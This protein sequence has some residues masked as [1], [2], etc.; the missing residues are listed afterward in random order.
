MIFDASEAYNVTS[1][2]LSFAGR[3][4]PVD[5]PVAQDFTGNIAPRLLAQPESY[6]ASLL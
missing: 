6:R 1:P 5:K 2:F 4:Q 3:G